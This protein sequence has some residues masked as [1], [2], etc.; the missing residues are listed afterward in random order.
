MATSDASQVMV[1]GDATQGVSATSRLLKVSQERVS[2][3]RAR[4]LRRSSSSVAKQSAHERSNAIDQQRELQYKQANDE[5]KAYMI[6]KLRQD[7]GLMLMFGALFQELSKE[8][9]VIMIPYIEYLVYTHNI[10]PLD[11]REWRWATLPENVNLSE[12]ERLVERHHTSI[13]AA[14]SRNAPLS[15]IEG[16]VRAMYDA[17]KDFVANGGELPCLPSLSK[18]HYEDLAFGALLILEGD[19][20]SMIE[21]SSYNPTKWRSCMYDILPFGASTVPLNEAYNRLLNGHELIPTAKKTARESNA[22]RQRTEPTLTASTAHMDPLERY[23]S[24]PLFVDHIYG[25]ENFVVDFRARYGA[26]GMPTH[27]IDV[28][29]EER[30]YQRTLFIARLHEKH[31]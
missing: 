5:T 20:H 3:H 2:E 7:K 1:V 28:M 18:K 6:S 25:P 29:L 10:K 14:K 27:S 24:R 9:Y 19:F 16:R 12:Y 11:A 30:A 13:Q 31:Q 23:H 22:S 17:I 15:E 4:V 26:Y 21:H 8:R